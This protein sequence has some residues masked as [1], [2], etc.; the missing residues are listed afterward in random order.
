MMVLT[1][2]S[3]ERWQED[4]GPALTLIGF[5]DDATSEVLATCFQLE[6]E[7]TVVYLRVLRAMVEQQGFR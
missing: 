6:C 1:D 3:R 7:D 5:Q 2:V 4:R